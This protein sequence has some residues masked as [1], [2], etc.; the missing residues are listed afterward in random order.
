ME[1]YGNTIAK[2]FCRSPYGYKKDI[3]PRTGDQSGE[4][5]TWPISMTQVKY[6]WHRATRD[7]VPTNER[8]RRVNLSA[9]A[10]RQDC[11][12]VGLSGPP[13]GAVRTGGAHVG[14]SDPPPGAVRTGGADVGLDP[15]TNFAP[16][17]NRSN[18]SASDV[19]LVTGLR[20]WAKTKA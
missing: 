12:V 7:T 10:G 9:T 14:L 11:C 18:C 6:A 13:P 3:L 17:S 5:S 4:K 1:C 19:V 2:L 20:A 8:L 15:R 16:T